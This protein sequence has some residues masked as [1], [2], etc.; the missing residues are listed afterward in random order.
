MA[1]F[2]VDLGQPEPEC[3]H[4]GFYLELRMMEVVLP[5]EL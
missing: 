1:F 5:L 4:S 3:V 2:H